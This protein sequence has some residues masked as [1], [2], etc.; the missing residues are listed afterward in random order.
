VGKNQFQNAKTSHINLKLF[1]NH[2]LQ[3]NFS[4]FFEGK[5]IVIDVFLDRII[6]TATSIVSKWREKGVC[7]G[8]KGWTLSDFEEF[9]RQFS[10]HL[11]TR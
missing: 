11:V 6:F 2:A 5:N 9:W 8:V 4:N 1:Q 10:V 3:P 7:I